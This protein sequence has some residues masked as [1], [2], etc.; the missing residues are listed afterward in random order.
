[1]G[2]L[3]GIDYGMRRVGI[4]VTDPL[5]LIATPVKTV[6]NEE[7]LPFLK[8]YV[9]EE[10]VDAMIVGMSRRLDGRASTM[11]YLT[12]K[13]IRL[14]RRHFPDHK[15]LNHDERYTS[16][17]AQSSLVLGGFKQ[18]TRRDKSRLD[19]ISAVFILR[20]FLDL[21]SSRG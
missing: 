19:Q 20:S 3:I 1:M 14:L 2:R 13:F 9:C 18:K 5:C 21:R 6:A 11:V 4:A 10:S 8:A 16:Q 15:V 17:Q 12:R 7:I